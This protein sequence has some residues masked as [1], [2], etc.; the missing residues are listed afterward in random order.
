MSIC[1]IILLAAC[2]ANYIRDV[3][4]GTVAPSA[5]SDIRT[6]SSG[7]D[8]NLLIVFYGQIMPDDFVMQLHRF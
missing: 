7:N 2:Q 3:K 1:V 8:S 5:S 4:G 6:S